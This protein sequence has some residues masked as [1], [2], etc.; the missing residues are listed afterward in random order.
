MTPMDFTLRPKD[1]GVTQKLK[2]FDEDYENWIRS[3]PCVVCGD[4]NTVIHH[5]WHRRKNSYTGIPLCVGH[6]THNR[7]AYHRLEH[8]EFQRRHKICLGWVIINLQAYY[9]AEVRS[10]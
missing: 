1:F 3:L 8:R 2:L 9:L 6:H 7:D 4:P 5:M 10:K